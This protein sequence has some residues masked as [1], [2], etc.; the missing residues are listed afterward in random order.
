VANLL[1][2]EVPFRAAGRDLFVCY[3]TRELAE[4][5]TAL[6]FRRPDPFQPDVA[7]EVDEPSLKDGKPKLDGKGMATFRKVRVLVDAAE[8]QRRMLTA[9]EAAW[10]R[11]DPE[12]ALVC[13]RISLRPWERESGAKLSEEEFHRIAQALGLARI[14]LLHMEAIGHG[15]YL[16]G[17]EDGEGKAAGA[18]SVS[19]T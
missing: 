1:R 9:F 13:F 15:I 17:E 5:Q 11:P 19:T 18:A 12:A 3:G 2:G 6:G 4:I 10:L 8:R 7:E 16:K 14:N